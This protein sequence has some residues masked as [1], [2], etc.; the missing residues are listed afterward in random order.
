M[1]IL[2]AVLSPGGDIVAQVFLALPMII[3]YEF[4]I[5]ISAVVYKRKQRQKAQKEK[6]YEE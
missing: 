1:V 4:S 3:L 5:I 6:E 2:A